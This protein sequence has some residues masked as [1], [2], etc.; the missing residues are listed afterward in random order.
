MRSK[1]PGLRKAHK[2]AILAKKAKDG[3]RAASPKKRVTDMTTT[4][5]RAAQVTRE[6]IAWIVFESKAGPRLTHWPAV[7]SNSWAFKAA[8]AILSLLAERGLVKEE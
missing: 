8:D 3:S 1:S 7:Y 6:E 2:A 5:E 4:Q